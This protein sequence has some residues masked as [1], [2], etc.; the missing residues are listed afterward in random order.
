MLITLEDFKSHI[1]IESNDDDAVLKTYIQGI[2]D[3]IVNYCGRA[4]ESTGFEE[5]Y[6]GDD[7]SDCL[8]LNNYP[9]SDFTNLMY[10]SGSYS[11]PVWNAIDP[12]QYQTDMDKGI[13]YFDVI[14]S[15]KRNIAIAYTAGYATVPDSIKLAAM[16]LVAKIYNK[17]RS[18]GFRHEEAGGAAI[19]WDSFLSDDVQ[20]LLDPYR[21][22]L[23]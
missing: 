20:L 17:R 11:D 14:Y 10:N 12:S 4:I 6:D 2:S 5:L 21:K 7:I 15:G 16:K 19:D 23:I 8:F 18:D 22:I 3:F 1:G 13:I 9:I